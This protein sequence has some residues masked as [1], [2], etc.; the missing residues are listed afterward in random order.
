MKPDYYYSTLLPMGRSNESELNIKEIIVSTGFGSSGAFGDILKGNDASVYKFEVPIEQC[1]WLKD[2][3]EIEKM[4]M[5]EHLF[6]QEMLGEIIDDQIKVFSSKSIYGAMIDDPVSSGDSVMGIDL[7]RKVDFTAI[8]IIDAK[9]NHVLFSE[10]LEDP[11]F[12]ESWKAQFSR[13]RDLVRKWKPKD[14]YIDA[15][16]LGDVVAQELR[17]LRPIEVVITPSK[18][19]DMIAK[20]QLALESGSLKIPT[21]FQGL[22]EELQSFEYKDGSLNK[23][24]APLGYHDDLVMSLALAMIGTQLPGDLKAGDA[25]YIGFGGSLF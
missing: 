22:I 1:W 8:S 14:I 25:Y 24:G 3:L 11:I 17:D 18:K 7:G 4:R 12:K 16:G 2:R 13:I 23:M 20:L 6:R 10:R 5:P 9:Y 21:E 15:T 19:N